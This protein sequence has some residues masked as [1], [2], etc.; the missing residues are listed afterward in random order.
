MKGP[1]SDSAVHKQTRRKPVK[2]CAFCRQRK[3]KCD[4][5]RPL[6]SSC[7]ARG[8]SSCV[9][10]LNKFEDCAGPVTPDPVPSNVPELLDNSRIVASLL[11][12]VTSL[13]EQLAEKNRL[14]DYGSGSAGSHTADNS[15]QG[16]VSKPWN[17]LNKFY[18]FQCKGSGRRILYGPTSFRT[19]LHNHRFGFGEKY[20]QIW[21]KIKVER[22]KWKQSHPGS[23]SLQE[24]LNIED[25]HTPNTRSL[26]QEVCASLPSFE[27]CVDLINTFFDPVYSQLFLVNK[28]LD[29]HKIMHDF[30]SSFIPTNEELLPDGGR[31]IVFLVP[32][33]K[34]NYYKIGVILMILSWNLFHRDTPTAITKFIVYLTGQSTGKTF[35][36]ERAQLLFLSSYYFKTFVQ[37]VDD[38]HTINTISLLVS[39]ALSLGLDRDI[40]LIYKG[41]ENVV[42][43]IKSLRNLWYSIVFLD[44]ESSFRLGRPLMLSH[45]DLDYETAETAEVEDDDYIEKLKKFIKLTRP[46]QRQA[47][48]KRGIPQLEMFCDKII[49]FVETCLPPVG[50]FLNKKKFN[51]ISFY[52]VQILSLAL[53]MI[54]GFNNLRF[55]VMEELCPQVKATN[56][57]SGMYTFALLKALGDRCFELDQK[58]FPQMIGDGYKYL[59][60]YLTLL[61]NLSGGLF[62]RTTSI[63]S[64]ILYCHLTMFEN[65][66]FIFVKNVNKFK[67]DLSTLKPPKRMLKVPLL[68]AINKYKEISDAWMNPKDEVKRQIGMRSYGFVIT[69][70]M[71]FTVRTVLDKALEYRKMAENSW[72]SQLNANPDH[73]AVQTREMSPSPANQTEQGVEPPV[74]YRFHSPEL[75]LLLTNQMQNDLASIDG[76]TSGSDTV[77]VKGLCTEKEAEMLQ[78]ITDEFWQS[79]NSGWE[80]L[81]NNPGTIPLLDSN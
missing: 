40:A 18:Y 37:N 71:Y 52:D 31:R 50:D 7:R 73:S 13:Q 80:E 5:Q 2:S 16:I 38:T 75:D 23:S 65:N 57:Q 77:Q 6:C 42:G 15:P 19:N 54:M 36:I 26:I 64:A 30:H 56:L 58:Y 66:D 34:K 81:V 20:E 69:K 17:P 9:Y 22:N 63:I 14:L 29:K 11:R 74:S 76:S 60:P 12:Q 70:H 61:T 46:F 21:A 24:L 45:I 33:T 79:Y 10:A 62:A 43:S 35:F 41:Q 67:W 3:L 49:D 72:A 39:T 4:H 8:L 47:M 1:Q 27:T 68:A 51:N 28:V 44:L 25:E 53:E 55:S 48:A 78:M 32:S 59:P